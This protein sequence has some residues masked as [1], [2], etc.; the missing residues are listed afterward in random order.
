MNTFDL[1]CLLFKVMLGVCVWVHMCFC[2]CLHV[3]VRNE[4]YIVT[5]SITWPCLLD[6]LPCCVVVPLTV[7]SYHYPYPVAFN[8]R[9]SLLYIAFLGCVFS[10][11]LRSL[12]KYVLNHVISSSIILLTYSLI[13]PSSLILFPASY[14]SCC[15]PDLSSNYHSSCRISYH[16]PSLSLTSNSS[17]CCQ[18]MLWH[19]PCAFTVGSCHSHCLLSSVICFYF[20]FLFLMLILS[21]SAGLIHAG[22]CT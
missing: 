2:V 16:L 6:T 10:Q 18:Y 13:L 3:R 8:K 21:I 12:V 5:F 20:L 11:M 4:V 7:D 19:Q 14:C 17:D 22:N 1:T 9:V 15:P